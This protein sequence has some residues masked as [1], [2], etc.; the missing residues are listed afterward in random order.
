MITEIVVSEDVASIYKIGDKITLSIG[1]R[2][3]GNE[4]IPSGYEYE[5]LEWMYDAN[6][7]RKIFE[8]TIKTDM[9]KEFTI[10]GIMSNNDQA[11]RPLHI[12]MMR[13]ILLLQNGIQTN[14]HVACIS[15]NDPINYKESISQILGFDLDKEYEYIGKTPF[16]YEV[17]YELLRWEIFA[18]SDSTI[19]MF[20]AVY[21]AL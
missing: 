13:D 2:Y 20:Y 7:V 3:A 6:G 16:E 9:K 15:L 8:E 4:V 12:R 14:Q 11:L 10:V 5:P 17:N 18:F 1:N 19:T 21:L